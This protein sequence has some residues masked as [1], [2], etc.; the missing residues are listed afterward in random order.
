MLEFF[1]WFSLLVRSI[2]SGG[3]YLPLG[4][5]PVG[6]VYVCFN[7][8]RDLIKRESRRMGFSPRAVC[9]VGDGGV[10]HLYLS[11]EGDE[12]KREAL[13]RRLREVLVNLVGLAE[14]RFAFLSD[15]AVIQ[16]WDETS[17]WRYSLVGVCVGSLLTG[18]VLGGLFGLLVGSA[19][20][21]A[22]GIGGAWLWTRR[23]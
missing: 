4:R 23:S 16:R 10:L 18:V 21:A 7:S 19:L 9:F 11:G 8:L 15:R 1:S 14:V 5:S 22:G 12:H 13:E 20:S 2:K 6:G 17:V 3:T